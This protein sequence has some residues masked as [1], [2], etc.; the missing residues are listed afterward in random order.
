LVDFNLGGGGEDDDD[1]DEVFV[2]EESLK[3]LVV[4]VM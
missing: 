4:M 2:G 1:G 3:L